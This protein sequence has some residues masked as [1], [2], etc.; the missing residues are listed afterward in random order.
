MARS[1]AGVY[2]TEQLLGD[3]LRECVDPDIVG[4]QPVPGSGRRI[5]PDYRSERNRL[6]VE[7]DGDAHYRQVRTIL[8]DEVRDQFFAGL[9]Y[10]VK[11]IPY[12][13]S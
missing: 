4:D 6:I 5:R 9:G 10:R 7:F 1:S 11:R 13:S 3:F 2:L 8:T 12:L